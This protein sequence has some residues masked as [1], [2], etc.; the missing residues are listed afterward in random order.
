MCELK[1]ISAID[2]EKNQWHRQR[3]HRRG[4]AYL[5]WWGSRMNSWKFLAWNLAEYMESL[6]AEVEESNTIV[7]NIKAELWRLGGNGR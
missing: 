3:K 4:S 7:T 1:L 6:K 5:R 2:Y